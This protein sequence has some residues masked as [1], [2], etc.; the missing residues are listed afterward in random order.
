MSGNHTYIQGPCQLDLWPSDSK[1]NRGH[2]LVMNNQHVK[3][4]DFVI[5]SF[6]D[7]ER[8]PL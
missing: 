2:L 8:K 5:N 1:I 6:Q 3:Y 7:N 4:K